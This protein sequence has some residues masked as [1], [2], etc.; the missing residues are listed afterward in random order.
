MKSNIIHHRHSSYIAQSG[1]C[2][3]CGFPLWES[4]LNSFA[5]AHKISVT[6]AVHL[7][8]TAEHLHAR[9]DGGGNSKQNI[10]AACLR[11]NRTRHKLKPA[12]SPGSY[13]ILVQKLVRKGR[14]HKKALLNLV[15][16]YHECPQR[17]TN[18]HS[19]QLLNLTDDDNLSPSFRS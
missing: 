10:V 13:R 11:C 14:W 7:Q 1:T 17:P 18:R 5:K 8:C 2:Y 15:G 12:P 9:Q 16:S 3:Y 4:D 6:N 19:H